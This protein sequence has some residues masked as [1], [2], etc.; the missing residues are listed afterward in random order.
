MYKRT[1]VLGNIHQ[2]T[3]NYI[4][5]EKLK[6]SYVVY[7]KEFQNTESFNKIY[8]YPIHVD[9]EIDNFCNFACVF[10]PIGQPNNKMNK[11][12]KTSYKLEVNKIFELL[13]EC[14]EIG[15][16]SI[17]FNIVNE[18][19]ANKNIFKIISYAKKL[20]FDDIY[21]ISNG[22]L[23]NE[24]NSLKILESG[25]TKIMF[26]LDAFSPETYSERRL[27]NKKPASYSKVIKNI[28]N[29]LD[30]KKKKNKKFPLVKVSF[31]VMKSNKH[32]INKFKKF[33]EN[34]VD[35]I[36]IQKFIDYEDKNLV[37]NYVNQTKCIMPMFRLS[38]KSDG[39]V[40]P[41]CLPYGENINLGNIYKETL[42]NIW[43]SKFMK[44]FQQ[45]HLQ[46]RAY[47]NK[48][49]TKCLKNTNA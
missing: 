48:F 33:W 43:N 30:I 14:K 49:C 8:P 19:L 35:A 46:N 34:K 5:D 27:K 20:N 23:L 10:C 47:E 26:S 12:Y 29:F 18:P 38:I 37:T 25:L 13:D 22:Y 40:R 6:K 4:K 45:M 7:R 41:C 15:V 1:E 36:H 42:L 28:L 9:I 2:K 32:E 3:L 11:F 39:N 24:K 17:Q 21:F 31:I 16:K 44:N